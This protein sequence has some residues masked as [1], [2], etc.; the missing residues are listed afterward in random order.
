[1]L[2]FRKELRRVGGHKGEEGKGVQ[3]EICQV[4]RHVSTL[5]CPVSL[6]KEIVRP[7]ASQ[8]DTFSEGGDGR[9]ED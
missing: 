4:K 6:E 3:R 7:M 2:W 9:R 5:F 8:I 1:M